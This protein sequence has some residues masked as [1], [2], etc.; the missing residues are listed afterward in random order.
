MLRFILIQILRCAMT[1]GEGA[2]S[3]RNDPILRKIQHADVRNCPYIQMLRRKNSGAL[4][5]TSSKLASGQGRLVLPRRPAARMQHEERK[6]EL[7]SRFTTGA[8]GQ[9]NVVIEKGET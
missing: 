8:I 6:V 5:A 9:V 2:S 7:F 4:H 1:D 3:R